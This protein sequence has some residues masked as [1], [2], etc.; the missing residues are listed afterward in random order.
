M[1]AIAV[2]KSAKIKFWTTTV[3]NKT[4]RD[5]IDF[6][7]KSAR[8][9]EFIANFQ[10]LHSRGEDYKSCFLNAKDMRDFLMSPI[11]VRETISCLI[12]KKEKKE[13]VGNSKAYLKLLLDWEDY[14]AMYKN[15]SKF[16][17]WAG[18]R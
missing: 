14:P 2:L 16:R 12:E 13:R 1:E 6:I 10:I 18:R 7:L 8:E 15:D 3:L 17:C 9:K 5:S 11:E 4:N